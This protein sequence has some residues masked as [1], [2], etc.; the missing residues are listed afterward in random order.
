MT[1]ERSNGSS[2]APEHRP[3]SLLRICFIAYRGNMHCGGQGVYLWFLTRELA[4]LGHRVDVLV[5]PPYP[6]PMP[7][8]NAVTELPNERFWGK[9]FLEDRRH[10]IPQP[11]PLRIFG[12]LNF[13]ELAASYLG[14]LPEPMAFSARAFREVASRLR[15]GT[16]YD[17]VHDVQCLGYGIL[18]IRKL[19]LPV[20]T[21]VHHPLT[22]DRRASFERDQSLREAIGTMGFYPVAMQGF[23][24]RRLD[25]V[26]TSSTESARAI[27]RD[28]RI[29]GERIRMVA[30]GVDTDLFRPSPHAE[31]NAAEILCVGR[32]SDP[33]KGIGNLIASLAR[34]PQQLRLTLV[35]DDH[36]D[37]P[38]RKLA[39]RLGCADRLEITG[40]IDNAQ[41][42]RR[43]QRASLVVVPSRYE[44]FGLPA[45]EAM[46]CGTPVVAC[47]AGALA[48]VIRSIGGGV[49]VPPEEPE[50]LAAAIADLMARPEARS[51]LGK[52]GN[53]RV[54]QVFAW[55]RIA[56]ATADAYAEIIGG[57]R[58]DRG[59][60]ARITTSDKPGDQ[61]AMRSSP[62]STS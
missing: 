4:R 60:P 12:P 25:G 35:D 61:R 51:M 28:F 39:R 29:P 20:V 24:A 2:G 55:P 16:R 21:T 59:R 56:G 49:L 23:V 30:N 26:F 6:D 37:N 54:N 8:A 32:A 13:Y 52:R 15:A 10:F 11:R 27:R 45:V 50:A 7:F 3:G 17:I 38:A 9:W 57:F 5:G 48:E 41:L 34:L 1:N 46:A 44:G 19:G 40:R 14:F 18:G 58:G 36:P 47:A 53:V 42:V 22:V 43:Y 31:R 62:F 33:N